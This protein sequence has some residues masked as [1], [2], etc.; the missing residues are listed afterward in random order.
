MS[1]TTTVHVTRADQA[2]NPYYY[3]PFAPRGTTR[4]T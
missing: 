1:M 4:T 3:I 2:A